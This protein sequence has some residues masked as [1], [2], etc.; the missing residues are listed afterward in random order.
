ME[1]QD[2]YINEAIRYREDLI[3]YGKEFAITNPDNLSDDELMAVSTK[4]F[5]Q[6]NNIDMG[7]GHS[8]HETN[9]KLPDS[10]SDARAYQLFIDFIDWYEIFSTPS[11]AVLDYVLS[12]YPKSE[13]SNILCVGDGEKS[14]LGRKLAM[15]GYNVISV[16]PAADT[17]LPL[18]SKIKSSGGKFT[19]RD[20]FFSH[21][22]SEYI[23]WADLI[24]GSKIPTL[25]EE[26]LKIPNKPAVF[27]ISKNAEM[28]RM[29][30]R[31]IPI[32]SS[33]QFTNLISKQP[34][35]KTKS[36][37]Y[38]RRDDEE[39]IIVFEK[40]GVQK[41]KPSVEQQSEQ[42][43]ITSINDLS[44]EQISNLEKYALLRN[45]APEIQAFFTSLK[46]GKLKD[47][48]ID[49]DALDFVCDGLSELIEDGLQQLS[50]KS[51]PN[52]DGHGEI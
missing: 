28:Y 25:V 34:N 10:I 24:V 49:I 38:E 44:K 1:K 2:Y 46:S 11:R 42:V 30:F 40:I 45:K 31:G 41:A 6:L 33:K 19:A 47:K 35:I 26:I 51:I 18:D 12:E 23:E 17:T 15:K 14:H 48:T 9:T 52:H 3:K 7:F 43:K 16:D 37:K 5:E 13:F 22:S 32:T 4:I 50:R 29:A 39:P 20:S 21:K 36:Y 8:Y 27:A